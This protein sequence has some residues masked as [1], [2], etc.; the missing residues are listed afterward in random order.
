MS[1]ILHMMVGLPR[2]GKSTKAKTLGH[3][4]VELDAISFTIQGTHWKPELRTLIWGLAH[5]MVESLFFAGHLNVI[6]DGANHTHENRMNWVSDR[7]SVQY[8]VIDTDEETCIQRAKNTDK[9]Y[10]IPV[11]KQMA[12][13]WEPI[14]GPD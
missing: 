7:W 5:T 1:K 14:E 6:L 12:A 4:I 9:L 10:L 13:Q 2:S 3:P 8:H 11:I